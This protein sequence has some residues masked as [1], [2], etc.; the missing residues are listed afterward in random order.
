[1]SQ[2]IRPIRQMLVP[3]SH[4]HMLEKNILKS[5]LSTPTAQ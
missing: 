1:M 4:V 5:V 2:K 3:R